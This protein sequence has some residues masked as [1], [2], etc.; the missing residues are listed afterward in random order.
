MKPQVPIEVDD[1]TG[2]WSTDGLP[3]LYVPRHFFMNNHRA[4]EAALGPQRYSEII[5]DAGYTSARTWCEREAKTHNLE[6]MKVFEHYLA[7]ISQ[8]GWGQFSFTAASAVTGIA[9]IKL[10]HSAFALAEPKSE[11]KV[12]TMFSGWFAGA[13][14]WGTGSAANERASICS[15]VQCQAEGHDHCLFAVR[16]RPSTISG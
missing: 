5:Y 16:R 1:A 15:E 12:C 2:V 3:M 8:R 9:D 14:D 7:R 13:M 11:G 6:G 10:T 4:V